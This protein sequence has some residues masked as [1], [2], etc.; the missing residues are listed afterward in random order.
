[1]NFFFIYAFKSRQFYNF[2][3]IQS[4]VSLTHF[5]EN[6]ASKGH[7]YVGVSLVVI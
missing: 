6:L 5:I 4:C 7:F 1:M 2:E 3:N